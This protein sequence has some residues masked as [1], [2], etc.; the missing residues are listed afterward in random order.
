MPHNPGRRILLSRRR[1]CASAAAVAEDYSLLP[2]NATSMAPKRSPDG[3]SVLPTLLLASLAFFAC[4]HGSVA[5]PSA[6]ADN[7][8][9]GQVLAVDMAK[10][11]TSCKALV[12]GVGESMCQFVS[13]FCAKTCDVGCP[14]CTDLDSFLKD[15]VPA[16][17]P[18]VLT[19]C[20]TIQALTGVCTLVSCTC[21]TSRFLTARTFKAD[22]ADATATAAA[23][24]ECDTVRL[25][26]YTVAP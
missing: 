2:T 9:A 21:A 24:N 12:G 4:M 6:C 8:E 18:S 23:V 15:T 19:D 16:L 11:F 7:D 20:K 26:A 17:L 25:T 13:A 10:S 14:F 22:A 5:V 3:V 1:Y